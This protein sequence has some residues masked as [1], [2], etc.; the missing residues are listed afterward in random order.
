MFHSAVPPNVREHK[1]YFFQLCFFVCLERMQQALFVGV[2][3]LQPGYRM[4]HLSSLLPTSVLMSTI[5]TC[6]K[7]GVHFK[8]P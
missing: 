2:V 7:L 1:D 4:L 3:P 5:V 8:H 6:K